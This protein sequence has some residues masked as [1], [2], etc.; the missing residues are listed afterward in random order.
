MARTNV[1]LCCF[2]RGVRIFTVKVVFL[3]TRVALPVLSKYSR[4]VGVI[5]DIQFL[6]MMVLFPI[7]VKLDELFQLSLLTLVS[8][9]LIYLK[10]LKSDAT[11][12]FLL[13]KRCRSICTLFFCDLIL[14]LLLLLLYVV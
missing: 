3:N 2:A 12:L 1:H 7:T 4:N 8:S 5:I 6:M 11:Q 13:F 10:I 14:L 9:I